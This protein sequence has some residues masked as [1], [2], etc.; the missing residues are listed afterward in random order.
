MAS[1]PNKSLV[2][3]GPVKRGRPPGDT[4]DIETGKQICERLAAGETLTGICADSDMPSVRT[5]SNWMMRQPDFFAD[6]ARAR[7]QQM[8]LEAEQIREIADNAYEDY[9]IDWKVDS[10]TGDR[11]P[12]VVVN[13]ESVKRAALRI[14]ARKWR[15]AA[16]NRRFYGNS[17]KHEH[18]IAVYPAHGQEGLPPGLGWLAGQLPGPT[19]GAGSEP[20]DSG[21]GEE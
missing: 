8:H 9:Y 1:A 11:T 7:E 14:D 6:V 18:D 3:V 5:V 19:A 12:F 16:L 20:D 2:L 13:S 4:Y 17:V 15:A 21:V 10:A